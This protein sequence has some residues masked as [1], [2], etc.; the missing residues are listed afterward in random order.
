M[1]RS[2]K[3]KVFWSILLSAAGVLLVILLAINVLRIAQTASKR[4]SIL[5]TALSLLS[6]ESETDGPW[7]DPGMANQGA[8]DPGMED[9]GMDRGREKKR[10]DRGRS[11]LLRSV[12]EGELGVMLVDAGGSVVKTAGCAEQLEEETL[13]AIAAAALADPDG[14]GRTNGWE[15]K[16]ISIDGGTGI[17]ILDAASLRR[18]NLETALLSLG[19]FA[20]ACGL[21]ALLA[22][23]LSKT[24]VRPVEENTEAQKRFVADAS[25]ELKTPLTVID[26]NASVLEQSIGQNKWLDYI[27]EQS[28]RMSGLV[29]ELLQLS[30][31]EEDAAA[32]TPEQRTQFDAAEAVMAA[33]LPFESVA[34]ERGLTLETD[35]PETLPVL[36]REKDLEQLA[37]ILIDNAIK[38]SAEGGTVRVSLESTSE[39]HGFKET[40]MLRLCVQNQGD[41]IPAEALPHLFDRFYRA[42]ASRTHKDNSYGLGLAIAKGLA[43]RDEGTVS[44]TSE[45]GFTEFTV[46][47]PAN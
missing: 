6:P 7:T 25:H 37:G 36:G 42:D 32:G 10:D 8:E 29:N 43:E 38:H 35:T 13:S 3:R 44:V 14:R 28:G 33:A 20:A 15:F 40:P 19:A 47:L 24:I 4:D 1:I 41:E 46:Q 18:E 17:S 26:A 16:A 22:A 9:P 27:K 30:N 39:R 2:L 5:D 23:F 11:E 12:S 34:F 21:F 31:L 45:S